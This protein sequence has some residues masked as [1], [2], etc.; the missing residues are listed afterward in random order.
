MTPTEQQIWRGAFDLYEWNHAM[1]NTEQC[2]IDFIRSLTDYAN[3]YDWQHCPLTH[4]L[5]DAILSAVED[6]VK[7]RMAEEAQ[8]P[9]QISIW[10]DEYPCQS[11]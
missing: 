6:E 9:K 3:R 5:A 8:K 7:I 4:R 11:N 10:S 1:P 2:W